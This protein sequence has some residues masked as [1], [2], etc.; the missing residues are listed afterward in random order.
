MKTRVYWWSLSAVLTTSL[1]ACDASALDE[2]SHS[3]LGRSSQ[4]LRTADRLA[5]C[6]NDPRVRANLVSVD[7]CVGADLFFREPFNGNGRTCASCHRAENNFTIDPAFI[8]TL[9]P[10]DP[11]FVAEFNPVLANLERPAQMRALSLILENQDGF[12]PDPNVRFVLRSVPHALSLATSVTRN[13]PNLTP[14]DFT[15]WSGDGAP[16]DGRLR[17]FQ[18]GAIIQHYTKSLARVVDVDFRLATD[19]ELDSID[20][21]LRQLGRT[22]ELNLATVQL[23]DQ[24]AEAG[25]L[26]FL[27]PAARCN[28]CHGNAGANVTFGGGGNL[29]FNTGVESARLASLAGFPRDGGLG[30]DA[31]SA[32]WVD[33]RRTSNTPPLI[34]AANTGPFF[35]TATTITGASAH[36]TPISETIE[37]AVA[38]YDS[39][40][41]NNSPSGA[42]GMIDLTE[43][44]IND[45]ARFLRVS[46]AAFNLQMARRRLEAAQVLIE[47][48][49]NEGIAIQTAL[50]QLADAELE[51]AI[52]VLSGQA[53]LYPGNQGSLQSA[54]SLIRN[55][56]NAPNA[57]SR[58]CLVSNA[59]TG[60]RRSTRASEVV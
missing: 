17:D 16:N 37:Q 24:R 39:P 6:E 29:N 54:Q 20:A 9:P 44:E 55:A 19:D 46:N 59:L 52:R 51:D 41:F 28:G 23:A 45:V 40:A 7:V 33:R 11:L 26:T 56:V 18:T 36:N 38:F 42:A 31:R 22:N 21:F 49:P 8:A 32:G 3:S 58:R 10:T 53:G 57:A 50:L 12:E 2:G 15:G 25:R 27:S 4:A 35:H 14:V 43:A 47:A 5:A 13:A 30:T 1:L 60:S 48:M 34:E